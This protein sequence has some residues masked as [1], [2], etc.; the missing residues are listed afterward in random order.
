M[1]IEVIKNINI[2]KLDHQN[3]R[4]FI[5]LGNIYLGIAAFTRFQSLKISSDIERSCTQFLKTI[6]E[7]Y[8]HLVTSIKKIVFL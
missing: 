7:F 2:F 3:P 5:P 1:K 4:N 8:I 6:L